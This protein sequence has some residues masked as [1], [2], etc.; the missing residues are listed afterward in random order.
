[1]GRKFLSIVVL[2]LALVCVFVSCDDTDKD[3]TPN[4]THSYGEWETTKNATC[5][6][7]GSKVRYCACGEKQTE[8]I[9]KTEHS[10]GEWGVVKESTT[11]EKGEKRRICSECQTSESLEIDKLPVV[12]TVTKEEWAA[13]FDFSKYNSFTITGR[14]IGREDGQNIDYTVNI[15][16]YGGIL[17]CTT[18]GK[19]FLEEDSISTY[20]IINFNDISDIPL[21]GSFEWFDGLLYDFK[22]LSDF[23][24]S[25]ATY[26]PDKKA[27]SI[28]LETKS[29]T[30]SFENGVLTGFAFEYNGQAEYLSAEY[31]VSNI[32][33]TERF[34]VDFDKLNSE[35]DTAVEIIKDADEFYY[36]DSDNNRVTINK[37]DFIEFFEDFEIT[38]IDY[39]SNYAK[40]GCDF[41]SWRIEILTGSSSPAEC[42]TIE[43]RSDRVYSIIFDS[44]H[45]YTT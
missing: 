39:Y 42:I 12:T 41:Y 23:G 17:H 24:Y 1:M 37:A 44:I 22:S 38:M 31:T 3:P 13:A 18:N 11:T 10:F 26:F 7:E 2:I 30:F 33:T 45:I 43:M 5:T 27:Y 16:Y 21:D 4:H 19:G 28:V 14:E 20:K 9:G 34:N 29:A 36:Y 32:N 8:T 25:H 40:D 35:L 15:K 6:A